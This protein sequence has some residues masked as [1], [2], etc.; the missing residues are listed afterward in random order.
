MRFQTS[1]DGSSGRDAPRLRWWLWACAVVVLASCQ[2]SPVGPTLDAVLVES[3]DVEPTSRTA[4]LCCCRITGTAT[5][6]NSVP[7]HVTIKFS[8]FDGVQEDPIGST[9]YF[10]RDLRPFEQHQIDAA[11]LLLPCSSVR[12]IRK[13]VDVNGIVAPD[14]PDS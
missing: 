5:N 8:A 11:G 7:V 3:L 2:G 12:E 10:I 4:T 14:R 9:L 13:E 1:V 6:L